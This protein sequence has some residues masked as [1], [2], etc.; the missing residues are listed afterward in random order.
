M[1]CSLGVEGTLDAVGTATAPI[2][3][4]SINDNSVGG[5]TGSWTPTSTDWSGIAVDQ[6]GAVDI[7]YATIEYTTMGVYGMDGGA[8]TV[9]QS[10]LNTADYGVFASENNTAAVA[11]SNNTFTGQNTA[12]VVLFYVPDPLVTDNL[13]VGVVNE[14]GVPGY[15]AVTRSEPPQW[16]QFIG[17]ACRVHGVGHARCERHLAGRRSSPHLDRVVGCSGGGDVDD[18]AGCGGEG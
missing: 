14:P 1:T 10:T 15:L 6:T 12:A 16:E 5:A 9:S 11:V 18:R 17:L 7:A 8:I 2:T 4:T 13:R 3:F